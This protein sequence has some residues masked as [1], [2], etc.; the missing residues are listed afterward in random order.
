MVLFL[1]DP[2]GD[3]REDAAVLGEVE[4]SQALLDLLLRAPGLWVETDKLGERTEREPRLQW[5]YS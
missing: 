4:I 2:D 1:V 3:V 5:R